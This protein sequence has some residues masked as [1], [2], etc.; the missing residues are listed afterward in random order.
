MIDRIDPNP[1]PFARQLT[2][3]SRQPGR[4]QPKQI[5][6]D[7][8]RPSPRMR[9][10]V[11]QS[12]ATQS[13]NSATP[14]VVAFNTVDFD[15]V[16]LFA[17]NRFTIPLTGKVTESWLLH[18]HAVFVKAAGG[19]VRELTLR[20]NGTTSVA[21]SVVEP[22]TL[23]SLDV[24]LLINDPTPGDFYELVVNQDS[25]GAINLTTTSDHTYFEII[26]LW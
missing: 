11:H 2:P 4:A 25:G 16:G 5:T 20:K 8:T 10:H 21:Y 1:D 13:I 17:S 26:H 12:A 7:S 18:G 19:T 22:N 9:A 15:T 24:L 23:D 6:V 3:Q 14:T